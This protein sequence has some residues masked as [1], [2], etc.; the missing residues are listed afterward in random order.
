MATSSRVRSAEDRISNCLQLLT[1]M[2]LFH[3]PRVDTVPQLPR[4][5]FSAEG[6]GRSRGYCFQITFRAPQR[7]SWRLSR[8]HVGIA[9]T[10]TRSSV[11]RRLHDVARRNVGSVAES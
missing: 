1:L 2:V 11:G 6:G 3:N 5:A 8:E 7:L 10:F 4:V 9:A